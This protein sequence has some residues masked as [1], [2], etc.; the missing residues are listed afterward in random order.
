MSKDAG[1][2]EAE[3]PPRFAKFV[4]RCVSLG[5]PRESIAVMVQQCQQVG[6]APLKEGYSRL[7][8]F[9]VASFEGIAIGVRLDQDYDPARGTAA[10]AQEMLDGAVA[11]TEAKLE[12]MA[13][14][15]GAVVTKILDECPNIVAM[16]D[17]PWRARIEVVGALAIAEMTAS[18]TY[19]SCRLWDQTK[20]LHREWCPCRFTR[21]MATILD[22]GL[23][24]GEIEDLMRG[25]LGDDPIAPGVLEAIGGMI[26]KAIVI[27]GDQIAEREAARAGWKPSEGGGESRGMDRTGNHFARMF[28]GRGG[29]PLH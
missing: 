14:G 2:K 28:G 3:Y 10:G 12:A 29:S 4:E 27:Q 13:K 8:A 7:S 20:A 15:V 21:H 26:A 16:Y 6:P 24:A 25:G 19:L 11:S 17:N 1:K 22:A 5:F 9:S 23:D 18:L